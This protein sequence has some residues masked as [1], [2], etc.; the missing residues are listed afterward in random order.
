V[1]GAILSWLVRSGESLL[2]PTAGSG[3]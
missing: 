3:L 1:G 2:A